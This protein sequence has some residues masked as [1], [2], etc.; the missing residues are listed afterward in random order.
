M[1]DNSSRGV[2]TVT[3]S[4]LE[5]SRLVRRAAEPA[6]P[7]EIVTHAINRAARRLG[8]SRRTARA[9][10]YGGRGTVPAD[11]MDKARKIA[12]SPIVH[13]ARNEIDRLNARIARLEALL[14]ADEDFHR[15]QIDALRQM[16]GRP[17]STLD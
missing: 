2:K 11:L 14:M 15:P 1:P 7:G 17:N 8:I 12:S 3:A 16:A 10:W 4:V 9:Y 13:E 6:T 5:F